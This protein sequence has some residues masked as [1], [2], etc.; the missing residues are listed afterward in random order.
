MP[1]LGRLLLFSFCK[2][3]GLHISFA[4]FFFLWVLSNLK[5]S[6]LYFFLM[7][8]YK[9]LNLPRK[10]KKMCRT[11]ANLIYKCFFLFFV[12]NIKSWLYKRN[13]LYKCL[14]LLFRYPKKLIYEILSH[15]LMIKT[16]EIKLCCIIEQ[17]MA[18]YM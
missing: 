14:T 9:A 13:M 10:Q 8:R 16:V 15:F 17:I 5:I 7:T 18:Y 12:N 6:H 1:Y 4:R 2:F 3:I 11:C